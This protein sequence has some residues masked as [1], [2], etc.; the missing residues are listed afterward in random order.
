MKRKH[1]SFEKCACCI[2]H[3]P[4]PTPDTRH[5]TPDTRHPTPDTRHPT[6][7][8]DKGAVASLRKWLE[9]NGLMP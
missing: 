4:H 6:P 9:A 7:D 8:T 1:A 3:T 2:V 5:P